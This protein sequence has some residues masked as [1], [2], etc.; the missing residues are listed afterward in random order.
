MEIKKEEVNGSEW[1]KRRAT[2]KRSKKCVQ[3]A[4]IFNAEE[5]VETK[6]AN[7]NKIGGSGKK[8][9]RKIFN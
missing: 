9:T 4:P 3:R 6:R 1:R 2:R 5:K 7:N 8:S